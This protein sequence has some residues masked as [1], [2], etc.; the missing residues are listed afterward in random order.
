MKKRI[1]AATVPERPTWIKP[2]SVKNYVE[3]GTTKIYDIIARG[4]VRSAAIG[5]SSK[6][7]GA[8]L[9]NLPDLERYIAEHASGGVT[10][11][12]KK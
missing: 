6:K 12:E 10:E 2:S 9:I 4:L 5:G 11:T 7:A 8:R 3:L 1:P